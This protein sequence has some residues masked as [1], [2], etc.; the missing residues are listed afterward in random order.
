[1]RDFGEMLA[2]DGDSEPERAKC[3][4]LSIAAAVGL[5]PGALL[6]ALKSQAR[7][8]VQQIPQPKPGE[9]VSEALL[10]AFELAHD[11]LERDH[12]QMRASLL[13]FGDLV[14][15]RTMIGF[16]CASGRGGMAV[17]LFK[18][19]DYDASSSKCVLG[20]VECAAS[21]ARMLKSPVTPETLGAWQ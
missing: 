3:L 12:P 5:K 16:C 18:G 2:A 20:F 15:A 9:L 7:A 1:M 14:L 4:Y 17:E 8:F 13:W 10:Y 19:T 6:A 11:L 21:H